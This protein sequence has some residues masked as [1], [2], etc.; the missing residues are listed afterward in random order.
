MSCRRSLHIL[1]VF[2]T[3]LIV[4]SAKGQDLH[5]SQYFET[6][7]LRN[8]ALSGLFN[9]DIRIQGVY[10]NQWSSV[11]FPFQTGALNG[12]YKFPAGKGDDYFTA[13]LQMMVD[14]AG[15]VAL[16]SAHFL[17]ALN[18]HKSLSATRNTYLSMG[19]MGGVVSRRL[20]R[21]RVT[22]NN[23]FDGFRYNGSL[24]DG[25]TFFNSYSFL[26]VTVGLSL[27]TTMGINDEHSVYGGIAYHHLTKPATE[28]YRNVT[29]LPKWVA[30]AGLK[31]T[32]GTMN[33][34]TFHGDY[35]RQGGAQT[36]IAGA[37]YS[38]KLDDESQ[39]SY[40][41]HAG[42]MY[43]YK[44]AFI[45]IVRVDFAPFSLGF[46]YDINVSPLRT[47]SSGRGG[48][49]TSMSYQTFINSDKSSYEKVKCPRF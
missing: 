40:L 30:S 22:T 31:Y 15:A 36:M 6:P 41:V 26:D 13:G 16:T 27:S 48:L 17:P 12:E 33:Y 9:G 2:C 28:F 14:R 8:P 42:A 34:V 1:S 43:R 21:S 11:T 39:P 10:R 45:P 5:F 23:Q 19:F 38:L 47:V 4:G 29:H 18:F 7:M 20:D 32:L 44:D 25:E 37:M 46:S 35:Y 24:P 49:E 3:L